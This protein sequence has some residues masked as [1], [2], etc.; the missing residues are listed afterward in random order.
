MNSTLLFYQLFEKDTSTYTY[1]LADRET[2]EA[3]IIDPVIETIERDLHLVQELGLKLKYTLDTHIHADHVTASGEIRRRTGAQL[4]LGAGYDS[5]CADLNLKDGESLPFGSQ[6][7]KVIHTPGHTN[8]CVSYYIDNKIFTGDALLIR[9]CGRTDFQDGSSEHLFDSVREKIFSLPETT[10]VF[11]AHDY[12][13]FTKS[14]VLLEKRFNP[15]LNE[16]VSKE[17]FVNIMSELHLDQPKKIG[18]AV[19]ANLQCGLTN[20]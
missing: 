5:H 18:I 19:P 4:G 9:G 17:N 15:R 10:E 8:G 16:T 1:L 6:A 2:K 7:I 11:P 20:N 12:K 3:V 14:S 13:G